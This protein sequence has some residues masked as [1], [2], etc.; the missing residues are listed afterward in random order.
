MDAVAGLGATAT[1][2]S[3][4]FALSTLERY[5][6]G[7]KPHELAW[8]IS[9]AMFSL[10]SF[11]YTCGAAL[12]WNSLSFRAFYLFGAIL[13]VPYLALGTVYL[14]AGPRVGAIVHRVLDLA[15]ALVTGVLAVAPLQGD[16]PRQGLP[17]GR[18]IF[19]LGPRLMAAVGSGLGATVL[20]VGAIYSAVRLVRSANRTPTPGAVVSPGRLAVTNV[21]I[22]AG[23][24]VLG[25]GGAGF[26]GRDALVAFGVFLVVG[27][28]LLFAG[29]LVSSPGVA[30]PRSAPTPTESDFVDELR[31][32]AR[33]E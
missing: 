28:T 13:N 6:V 27:V 11:A 20:I 14:L 4:A 26:T 24:L 15:A 22:A 2:V 10:A 21:M 18:E 17:S 33:S 12:G 1:L 31:A 30:T 8:T 5:L 23:S 16:I 9:M 19:G 32:I 7:R 29:F 3:L 25:I